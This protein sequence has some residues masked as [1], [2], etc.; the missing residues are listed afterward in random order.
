[1]ALAWLPGAAGRLA[2]AREL[3]VGAALH[4][5]A[6]GDVDGDGV[7]DIIGAVE[8]SEELLLLHGGSSGPALIQRLR[9]GEADALA[10]A[11]LDSDGRVEVLVSLPHL[12]VVQLLV[13]NASGQLTP[14]TI[15]WQTT[16]PTALAVADLD[17]DGSV[18]LAAV[19]ELTRRVFVALGDGAGAWRSR[20]Q[21]AIDVEPAA[22]L[23]R[24]GPVGPE[25]VLAGADDRSV[26]LVDP[27]NGT[28][29]V[30]AVTRKAHLGLAVA[31]LDGDGIDELIH[32]DAVLRDTAGY[33]LDS[34]SPPVG[35]A[36][37]LLLRIDLDGDGQEELVVEESAQSDLI[38]YA[39]DGDRL[40][41]QNRTPSPAEIKGLRGLSRGD[42]GYDLAWW[43]A[44]SYGVLAGDSLHAMSTVEQDSV[45]ELV[46]MHLDDDGHQDVAVLT[47]KIEPSSGYEPPRYSSSLRLVMHSNDQLL[48][49]DTVYEGGRASSVVVADLDE[50]A[51]DD[52]W[53]AHDTGV[54]LLK[55]GGAWVPEVAAAIAGLTGAYPIDLNGDGTIDLVGC[56][57]IGPRGVLAAYGEGD[58]KL[59]AALHLFDTPCARVHGCDIDQDGQPE[60]VLER[61][62]LNDAG[63]TVPYANIEVLHTTA[64]GWSSGGNL[65][66]G[67]EV[68]QLALRCTSQGLS[69]WTGGGRG[70]ALADLVAGPALS[71][72]GLSSVSSS[73]FLG[74]IDGD[75]LDELVVDDGPRVMLARADQSGGFAP[76]VSRA[77]ASAAA[78]GKIVGLGEFDGE[79]GADLLVAEIDLNGRSTHALWVFRDDRLVR[80]LELDAAA[81]DV[82]GDFD[83]DG[84]DEL[85]TRFN[86]WPELIRPGAKPILLDREPFVGL[87]ALRAADMDGDGR[88]DLLASAESAS[89]FDPASIYLMRSEGAGFAPQRALA[90]VARVHLLGIGDL[91]HDK[92]LDLV[93]IDPLTSRTVCLR[94]RT[95]PAASCKATPWSEAPSLR[96]PAAV[97]DLDGDGDADVVLTMGTNEEAQLQLIRGDG[98]GGLRPTAP[99]SLVLGALRRARLGGDSPGW[100]LLTDS[101]SYVLTLESIP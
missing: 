12:G 80:T 10:V 19:D 61:S 1:M 47:E 27:L 23:V 30:H 78:F 29:K 40:V 48:P 50:D 88:D 96:W 34:Q 66:P 54:T 42:G 17:G 85:L 46:P 100:V 14:G 15:A 81:W 59:G 2:P 3:V 79:P 31:D 36:T 45:I 95:G 83:G 18:D 92:A 87:N 101:A 39:K 84:R 62:S 9:L 11:D 99:Q 51:L 21:W 38:V 69:V 6:V 73:A 60:I 44:V 5:L 94:G 71:E 20:S 72:Q 90:I 86:G 4:T 43:S 75:G 24:R 82:I 56:D 77:R 55:S 67:L 63:P 58:G 52:L 57:P 26:V 93:H 97:E 49:L 91:D 70:V 37:R 7:A 13:A 25:L 33:T 32:G 8:N 41:E 89:R 68:E 53:I 22:L 35:P 64:T 74:D 28:S 98:A 16:F 65:Y 76:A